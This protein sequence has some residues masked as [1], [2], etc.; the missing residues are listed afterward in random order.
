MMTREQALERASE[1]LDWYYRP[2]DI[3]KRS[4]MPMATCYIAAA[5][6]LIAYA[7][8]LRQGG[9]SVESENSAYKPMWYGIPVAVAE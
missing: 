7:A 4:K 2:G 1:Y 5:Q 9:D 8:E 3:G 6:A